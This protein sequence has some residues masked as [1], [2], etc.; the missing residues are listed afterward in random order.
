MVRL[1]AG[2]VLTLG[3]LVAGAAAAQS[4]PAS[5]A[6]ARDTAP[7]PAMAAVRITGAAPA[8]DGRLDDPAWAQATAAT[9]FVQRRPNAGAAAPSPTQVR[10]LYTES[11]LYVGARMT[12]A[13]DSIA[14]QLARRDAAGIYSDW[15]FVMLDS[16][17]DNRSAY[18]F[19]V[20][21]RE[22]Q[23]DWIVAEDGS[24][25][26]KWDAVWEVSAVADSAGWTAE[27]RIP[28]S[29]LRFNPGQG[30]WGVNF[31]RVV[32]RREE[33]DFWAPLAPNTPGYVS[34]FGVLTGLAGLSSPT[35]LELRPYAVTR[36][37]RADG[38]DADPFYSRHEPSA[39]MGLDLSY[40]LTPALTLTATVNP[41]FG[42]VEADPSEVNLTAFETSF[43][44]QRPF[45]V[46]DA[47]I[48][49]FNLG[50]SSGQLLY[51]RRIGAAPHGGVPG[52][53][54]YSD[55]PD[56]TTILGAAKVSGKT[57]SGWSLG[58]LSAVTGREQA[59]YVTA[60]GVR[61]QVAVEPLTAFSLARASRDFRG[62]QSAL[63]GIATLVN[64]RLDGGELDFLRSSALTGGVDGRHRFAS[65]YEVSGYL[66][67]SHIQ[68]SEQALRQ[69]QL[70]STHYFQRPDAP[71]L[72]LD[73]AATS[74]TGFIADLEIEKLGGGNWTWEMGAR[75]RSPGLEIN[76]FGFQQQ[77]DRA[78]LFA[79]V[80][81]N[82]FR[83]RGRFRSWSVGVFGRN[84]W[85]FGRER[86]ATAGS[87]SG[88]FEL[89][90][91]W[92]GAVQLDRDQAGVSTSEL[93]GGP[94]LVIPGRTALAVG[95]HGDRRRRVAWSVNA[96]GS[97]QDQT[98]GRTLGVSPA[99]ALRLSP[100]WDLSLAPS[101]TLNRVG[102]QYVGQRRESDGLVHYY[103]SR[104][105]QTT[106]ALTTRL[107]Y[108]VTP[109]LSLQYYA[110][111]F[112]SAGDFSDPMQVADPGAARFGDRFGPATLTT[113]P[114]FKVQQFRSN[115]VVRWE[116]RP[117]STLFVVWNTALQS[118]TSESRLDWENARTLFDGDGSNVLLVKLSYWVGL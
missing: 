29:Q 116:Y 48:F 30:A 45:F 59:R 68:G 60:D 90:N 4:A 112:L 92:G 6:A 8:L 15:L 73:S 110:Q 77:T 75:A 14:A 33:E 3:S 104:L 22:V 24:T 61:E 41:D 25:D 11:A 109:R 58:V 50:G 38:R 51:T 111:P 39:S 27:F 65:N 100:R 98:D 57:A 31:Q 49:Q 71:H 42:Q 26:P 115:A 62:G 52:G 80:D 72:G 37:T 64:R 43:T 56:G 97:V 117:G 89:K 107:N 86:V 1:S 108:T 20:N 93:R 85:T 46:Q 76:D 54:L 81:Y 34:R 101:V 96:A 113:L 102:A 17:D 18:V 94:S 114:D 87:L 2:M 5:A 74:L 36:L 70:N 66:V 53:S 28:L 13:P 99:V 83:P 88:E 7:P 35:R 69:V 67:G 55:V 78:E 32:A 84:Q 105:R 95:V 19:G 79:G 21:P 118:R 40:S 63:G 23:R 47:R 106:V 44:E 12:D 91:F 103:F 9:G 10:V 82:Q 16:D